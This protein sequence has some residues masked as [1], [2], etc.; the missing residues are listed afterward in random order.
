MGA[1]RL[2]LVPLVSLHDATLISEIII[3]F[4]LIVCTA[5]KYIHVNMPTML[6]DKVYN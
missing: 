5:N 1:S 4:M 3:V 2:I 6:L